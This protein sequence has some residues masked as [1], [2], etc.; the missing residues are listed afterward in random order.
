MHAASYQQTPPAADV[1]VCIVNWNTR[2]M[3][4]RCLLSIRA[5]SHGV[6]L[7]VI[8]VDNDSADGSADMVRQGFPEVTL[9]ATG[10]NLGFARGSN[11]AAQ[12][13][14]GAYV[15]YLNPDTELV[16]NAIRGM[17]AYM[18]QHPSCGATGCR[19]LNSD[20]SI[21]HTCASG[22]PT[23]RNELSSLLFLDR[24]FPRSRLFSS[25]ELNYW[26]HANSCDVDCLSGACLMLPAALDK[27]LK[28]F[29]ESLFMYGED[30][31]LCCR[32]RAQGLVLHYSA[33]EVIYHHE[34][35]ASKKRGRSFAP[36]LQRAANHYFLHKNFGAGMAFA[37]RVAVS[38][39]TAARLFA[40]G[41][42]A[43]W[44]L[45]KGGQR[46]ESF[47]NFMGKHADLFLWSVN[48]K[49]IPSR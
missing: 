18:Q 40:A 42:L 11:R 8:V 3:L 32:I 21:Q 47:V 38:I 5:C 22:F 49:Q 45:L 10:D 27:Q 37:Y 17:W 4:R 30:L 39:G 6:R 31:D 7:Q 29:D 41:L 14:V 13:A 19:L 24:L 44:W 35:A 25:R 16:S 20:G 2:E 34:G 33:S 9:I 48:A 28:G 43:P 23:P 12:A 46:R 36:L 26:D 15:L 1:S